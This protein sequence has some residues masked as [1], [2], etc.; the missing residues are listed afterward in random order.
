MHCT[1]YLNF[2]MYFIKNIPY[3]VLCGHIQTQLHI[4]FKQRICEGKSWL[5]MVLIALF[6]NVQILFSIG[7]YVFFISSYS[8]ASMLILKVPPQCVSFQIHF[9]NNQTYLVSIGNILA[10]LCN[11]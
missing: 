1:S 7:E 4:V 11:L 6:Y 9:A 10:R 2:N 8:I 3:A 5:L